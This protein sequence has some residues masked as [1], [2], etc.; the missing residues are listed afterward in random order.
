MSRIDDKL[1]E[2]MATVEAHIED[3]MYYIN[4]GKEAESELQI[5]LE[6]Q[7]EIYEQM[8]V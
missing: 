1:I 8:M 7:D 2:E 4:R 3:C 5:W 6:K